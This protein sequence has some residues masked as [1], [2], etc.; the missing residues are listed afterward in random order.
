MMGFCNFW[1]NANTLGFEPINFLLSITLVKEPDTPFIECVKKVTNWI[2]LFQFF[3][4]LAI[5]SGIFIPEPSLVQRNNSLKISYDFRL[6]KVLKD[7]HNCGC[8]DNT[9]FY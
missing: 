8:V 6:R 1:M 5:G 7:I 2:Y 9:K 3:S 4:K